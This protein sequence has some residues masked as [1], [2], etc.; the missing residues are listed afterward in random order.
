MGKFSINELAGTIP[1]L[2]TPFD[3]HN[4]VDFV[5]LEKVAE[6]LVELGVD[7]I[8]F[9]GL[10][11]EYEQLTEDERLETTRVV[12]RILRGRV[13]FIVGASSPSVEL[14]IKFASAGADAGAVCAMIMAPSRLHDQPAELVDYYSEIGGRQELAIM[15]QN[16]P[17]PS[18]AGLSEDEV[19]EIVEQ[20]PS[21]RF[22]KEETA[23]FGQRVAKLIAGAPENL[24]GVFGGAG[25]R[26]IIDELR[27]GALGTVPA[28]ELAEVHQRLLEAYRAGDVSLAIDYFTRMLPILNSQSVFR[29]SLTKHVLFRRGII[30]C[31]SVRAPGPRLDRSNME[32]LQGY[33]KNVESVMGSLQEDRSTHIA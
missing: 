3:S 25:G 9:P 8:V 1:V 4:E 6:H 14:A 5:S 10:A 15:L 33:W 26:H 29:C 24:I 22:V 31:P 12:G 19:L 16:A 13:P 20:V 17:A 23:P 18:G 21:I 30:S 32:E 28:C 27:R 2:P 11:S 7:G